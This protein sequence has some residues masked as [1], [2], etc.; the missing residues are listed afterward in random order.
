MANKHD[1]PTALSVEE[2]QDRL[3]MTQWDGHTRVCG[4]GRTLTIADLNQRGMLS[5]S[6]L[7][8]EA[9]RALICEYALPIFDETQQR[10]CFIQGT[11]ATTGDGLYEGLDWM[12]Q[13]AKPKN[14]CAIM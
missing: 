6:D 7:C 1:F 11:C 10:K 13:A 14:E 5:S 8:C 9:I 12:S 4:L 3:M 2:V